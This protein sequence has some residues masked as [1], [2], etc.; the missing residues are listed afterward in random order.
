MAWS[1]M[2]FGVGM[3]CAGLIAGSLCLLHRR[4]WRWLPLTMT[5]GGL[6]A[7]VPDWPRIFR[8]DF[9]SLPFASILGTKELERTLHRWGDLFFFHHA[10][11]AQPNEYA[12][13]G[14]S[15]VLLF[16]NLSIALLMLLEHR[17]RSNTPPK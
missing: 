1:T 14:L 7:T 6:W 13:H 9:P 3:G 10:L 12:L 8:E 11:D 17:A 5:L 15:L 16:Y 4:G 2:H